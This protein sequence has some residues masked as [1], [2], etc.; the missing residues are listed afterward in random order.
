MQISAVQAMAGRLLGESNAGRFSFEIKEPETPGEKTWF[1]L[2]PHATDGAALI[3][4]TSGVELG[5]GMGHYL[6]HVANVSFSW[7]GTGGTSF[8]GAARELPRLSASSSEARRFVRSAKWLN[9]WNVCTFSYS[10]VWWSFERWQQEIDLMALFGVN[11]PL[12]YVGQEAVVRALYA[13][14]PYNLTDADLS[15]FFSGPAWLTWQRSQ[16]LRGWGGPLPTSWIDDH[17]VL[18][19]KILTAMRSIGMTPV[20][21][22]FGGWVP[23]ALMRLYPHANISRVGKPPL[24]ATGTLGDQYGCPAMVDAA[25][26]LFQQ[27]GRGWM[28]QLNETYGTEDHMFGAD[29]F[30]STIHA[31]WATLGTEESR[32]AAPFSQ[33]AVSA[34]S[35]E[36]LMN[37]PP[38]W[39]AAHAKGAYQA[40]AV[41]DPQAVWVYQTYP[42]HQFIYYHKAVP[43]GGD[44]LNLTRSLSKAWTSAVPKGKLLLLDLWADAGL[45]LSLTDSDSL[46]L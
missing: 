1:E 28:Q 14:A 21:P 45:S 34:Q 19:R 5:A 9:T 38:E 33:D 10:F 31:P 26:P 22:A 8:G 16:G 36:L 40:M 27:L 18:Q 32:A 23:T 7:P 39:W 37:Q 20:L 29:G 25:D 11:L 46:T 6:R 17:E 12:A 13:K 30:F 35:F 43:G 42:W 41:S 44:A 2:A 4:G 3:R 24:C 15:A